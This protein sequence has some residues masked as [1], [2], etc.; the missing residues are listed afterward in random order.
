MPL[1]KSMLEAE[2]KLLR[3]WVTHFHDHSY[4]F[5]GIMVATSSRT[6]RP[7]RHPLEGEGTPSPNISPGRLKNIITRSFHMIFLEYQ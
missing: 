2:S 4:V 1:T 3:L 7:L 5:F 6:L